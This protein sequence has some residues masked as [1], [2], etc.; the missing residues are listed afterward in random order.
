MT[1]VRISEDFP[2]PQEFQ[3][4]LAAE[5][6]TRYALRVSRDAA[7][8]ES[9]L[10]RAIQLNPRHESAYHNRSEARIAQGNFQGGLEDCDQVIRLNPKAADAY[11]T[12]SA[13]KA[14][15]QDFAGAAADADTSLQLG[16][17]LP[18]AYY[19]RGMCLLYSG[20]EERGRADLERFLEL[21]PMDERVESVRATLRMMD[22]F[23]GNQS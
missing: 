4:G 7:T 9:L 18:I 10:T 2:V 23:G 14:G 1:E 16:I 8:A 21:A 19:N 15:L 20:Q 11:L 6:L 12:R 5:A 13:A 17:K 22:E 3:R